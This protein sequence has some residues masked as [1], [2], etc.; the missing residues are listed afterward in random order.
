MN[1]GEPEVK[2]WKGC[3]DAQS[4]DEIPEQLWRDRAD[5]GASRLVQ[6]N[7]AS[8]KKQRRSRQLG[9]KAERSGPG[10]AEKDHEH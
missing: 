5:G 9:Q 3:L 10:V 2:P 4:R 7:R 8:Y 6:Q 1:L